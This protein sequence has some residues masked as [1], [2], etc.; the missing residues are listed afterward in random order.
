[1]YEIPLEIRYPDPDVIARTLQGLFGSRWTIRVFICSVKSH[2]CVLRSQQALNG[3][4]TVITPRKLKSSEIE[5]LSI[6]SRYAKRQRENETIMD[7]ILSAKQEQDAFEQRSWITDLPTFSHDSVM[8]LEINMFSPATSGA[9]NMLESLDWELD[10]TEKTI[11][12]LTQ[13]MT[14]RLLAR[15]LFKVG[16]EIDEG[17]TALVFG[18]IGKATE[19]QV[20]K[21]V[22]HN[23]V[24]SFPSR[25][26]I[27]PPPPPPPQ[28]KKGGVCVSVSK[29]LCEDIRQ[30][31]R[32]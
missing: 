13:G 11:Q 7:R 2:A 30:V 9:I 21:M 16:C 22:S 26:S 4:I 19:N 3:I 29:I 24:S 28:K 20:V 1:M 5:R 31:Q 23:I 10:E 12:F 25:F 14:R 15:D 17:E 18:A 6:S 27:A 8:R 32:R